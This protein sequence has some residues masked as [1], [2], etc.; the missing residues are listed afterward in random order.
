MRKNRLS[1]NSVGHNS[2]VSVFNTYSN[3][4]IKKPDGWFLNFLSRD[5]LDGFCPNLVK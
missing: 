3:F 2:D 5:G 4:Y 1:V